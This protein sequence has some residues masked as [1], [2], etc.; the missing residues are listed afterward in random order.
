MEEI[1]KKG[2]RACVLLSG[3]MDSVAALHWA[4]DR[5][6]EVRA[7]GFDYGQPHRD[8]ELVAAGSTARRRKVPFETIALADTLHS[9]ILSAVPVHDPTHTGVHRA[10][11]PGRN[12]VFLSIAMSRAARWWP[13][14][15]FDLVIG[16]CQEDAVGFPD[17]THQF[18][19]A[20]SVVL[21]EALGR[22]VWVAAPYYNIAKREIVKSVM[23]AYPWGLEDLQSSWS[24]YEGKG[25]CGICTPCVLRSEAFAHHGLIDK[26]TP[27]K[28]GGGDVSREQKFF[29]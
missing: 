17:C 10:F 6:S 14:G 9:G 26:A 4:I 25:P 12:L 3:G 20:A 27:P 29:R 7:I 22:P 24:C 11:I 8:A 2:A 23:I 13:E 5:Y 15:G 19:G 1:A 16:A 21:S 28:M 18:I